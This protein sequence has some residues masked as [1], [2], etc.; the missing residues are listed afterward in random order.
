MDVIERPLSSHTRWDRIST[1]QLRSNGH[2]M[3]TSIRETARHQSRPSRSTSSDPTAENQNRFY[4]NR[5][6]WQKNCSRF[7]I[8][9]SVYTQSFRVPLVSFCSQLIS[10]PFECVNF[11]F[12]WKK[13]KKSSLELQTSSSEIQ[14]E[15][16]CIRRL[17]GS[18][19]RLIWVRLFVFILIFHHLVLILDFESS[20]KFNFSLISV[21]NRNRDTNFLLTSNFDYSA[22]SNPNHSIFA[23]V[24]SQLSYLS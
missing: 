9:F 16:P 22:N 20:I 14:N 5:S 4:K 8:K 2:Q 10:A 15:K 7:F 23:S 13:W 3:E 12:D 6:S 24:D 1:L 17:I 19:R 11:N 21:F 18:F